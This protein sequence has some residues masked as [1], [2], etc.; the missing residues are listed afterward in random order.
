MCVCVY[1]TNL[2]VAD[3][4]INGVKAHVVDEV[5]LGLAAFRLSVNTTMIVT[6]IS[7]THNTHTHTRNA[8]EIM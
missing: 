2:V 6:G 1:D 5:V 8:H 4:V 3:E 7:T